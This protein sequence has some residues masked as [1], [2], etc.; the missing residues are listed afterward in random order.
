VDV[1]TVT[2]KMLVDQKKLKKMNFPGGIETQ[3][4]LGPTAAA[5]AVAADS[6]C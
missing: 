4:R 2:K 5:P 6:M 3:T 1:G